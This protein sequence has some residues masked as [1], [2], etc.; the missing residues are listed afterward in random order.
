MP[1][2]HAIE[3][4]AASSKVTRLKWRGT[5]VALPAPEVGPGLMLPGVS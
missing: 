5:T 4:G 3:E 2:L 1:I